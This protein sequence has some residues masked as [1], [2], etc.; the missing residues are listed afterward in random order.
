MK[1]K[2]KLKKQRRPP[3]PLSTALDGGPFRTK[4]LPFFFFRFSSFVFLLGFKTFLC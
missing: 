4:I 1:W 2:D 3:P